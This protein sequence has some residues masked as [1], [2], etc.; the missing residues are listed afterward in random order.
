LTSYLSSTIS[1]LLK[2]KVVAEKAFEQ[3]TEEQ[4]F[5]KP[6]P[7]SNS[8]G[9]IVNHLAGI[10][11]SRW[12]NFLTEDGEKSWRNRENEFKDEISSRALLLERW[13]AG[14]KCFLETLNSLTDNDL[15]RTVYIRNEAHTVMEAIQ[16]QL[17]H[18]AL[19]VGQIIF[20]G[21]MQKGID[22]S[23]LSIPKGES[24][25]FNQTMFEK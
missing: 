17:A 24:E 9:I 20:L 22:W 19:H 6:D 16:R 7:E 15:E 3:L 1:T 5:W 14:W 12:T 21:K 18:Y 4:L 25:S 8:I 2:Y 13:N 10:M 23:S 11:I